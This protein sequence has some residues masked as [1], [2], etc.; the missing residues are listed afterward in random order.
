MPG[1]SANTRFAEVR[2]FDTVTSTNSVAAELARPGLVVVADHQSAG[3]GRLGRTWEAPPGSSL[4]A[5]VVLDVSWVWDARPQL[6]TLALALAASDACSAVAGIRPTLKW[7]NDLLVEDG[8]VGGI[9]AE[10]VPGA[11]VIVAGIGLNVRWGDATPPPPGTSLDA[12]GAGVAPTALLPA[13]L[14]LLEVRLDQDP[15]AL[16]DDYRARCT[17]LG[18]AV[19]VEAAGRDDVEGTAVDVTPDGHLLVQDET[20]E[21]H[22]VVAGDVVHVRPG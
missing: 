18:Q 11:G 16:L 9:L 13:L 6:A 10:A 21:V 22:T 3:Q 15:D 4:L 5:S 8:K 12:L 20:G 7:P 1:G 2:H 14:E 19:R 17:T